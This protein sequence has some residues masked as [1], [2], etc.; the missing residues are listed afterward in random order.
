MPDDPVKLPR[1]ESPHL[2]PARR[3]GALSATLLTVAAVAGLFA[4]TGGWLTLQALTP[5]KMIDT[6]ER[7]NGP[8]PGFRRNHAKGVCVSGYFDGNGQAVVLSKASVF[9][10]VRVPVIGRFALAGGQPYQADAPHT[11]RSMAL[12]FR[13][14]DGQEWRTGM[15]NTPVFSVNTAQAFYEQLLA[16]APDPLTGKPNPVR[17]AAFLASHP[18]TAKAIKLTR[19]HPVSSGFENT[20]FNSLNAFLFVSAHGTETPVRWSMIPVQPFE[21]PGPDSN[22][23]ADRDYLFESLISSVH[24]QPLQWHLVITIGD[25]G[26]PTNDATI[27][28]PSGRR[29][30]DA[31]TLTIDHIESEETSL[32]RDI[33]FDPLVLPTGI[34]PSDDPLLG[35]RSAAYSPSFT[36]REGESKSPSAVSSTEVGK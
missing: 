7:V 36:R 25:P 17:M 24:R 35:A 32:A 29:T 20:A 13:D 34:L 18:E 9:L 1:L 15:N 26:D 6:F 31:G 4:Y 33:N 5:S 28:W 23:N 10:A 2:E 14:P 16:S 8:H 21:P 22:A 11:V 30:I 19:S 3:I 12:L 27:P